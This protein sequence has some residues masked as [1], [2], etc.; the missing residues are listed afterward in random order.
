[1][2]AAGSARGVDIFEIQVYQGEIN[3]AG[4]AGVELHTNFVAAGRAAP[5]FAGEAV[6]NRSLRLTIE[7]SFGVLRFWE[8]G[9]YLQ[10]ATAPGRSQAHF[11][12]YKLR[13]KLVV[14]RERTGR[15]T[16]G[17]NMEV[18][19]GVAVLGSRDWDTEVRPILAWWGRR[20][21][22]A[23]NPILGWALTGET[24]AAPQIEPC[25][26]VRLD[27]GHQVGLGVEYYAG[28]G[29][30]DAIARLAQQQHV[31]Y[32]VGDLLDGPLELNAGVGR[33]LTAATDDWTFKVIVGKTF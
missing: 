15:W 20:W 30:L 10:L 19:R 33:G 12:G 5:V 26:K 8:L 16:V 29:R 32:L 17:L 14:P 23:V 31:L 13:S 28:L 11:G 9:A 4:Q 18:G 2:L 24:S 1:M 25:A 22:F 21:F 27:V 7:P 6:P 3:D